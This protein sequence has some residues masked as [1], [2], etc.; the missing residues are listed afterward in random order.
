M[1]IRVW[2]DLVDENCSSASHGAPIT[3]DL[4]DVVDRRVE[5]VRR[6]RRHKRPAVVL[7][8]RPP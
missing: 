5:N 4:D 8:L 6:K 1:P 3:Y 7:L 2:K